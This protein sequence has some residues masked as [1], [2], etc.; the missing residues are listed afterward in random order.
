MLFVQPSRVS[1]MISFLLLPM[2]CDVEHM[3]NKSTYEEPTCKNKTLWKS[4]WPI[5]T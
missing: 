5:Q 3:K 4:I 1:D 2:Q